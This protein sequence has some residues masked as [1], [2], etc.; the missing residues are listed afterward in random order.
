MNVSSTSTGNAG[1]SGAR[2]TALGIG[3]FGAPS[4]LLHDSLGSENGVFV[5]IVSV[6]AELILNQM[7]IVDVPP[8]IPI[9]D[10]WNVP[11]GV[12]DCASD[13]L[14]KFCVSFH[15][16]LLVSGNEKGDLSQ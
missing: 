2:G 11:G 9:K 12:V 1:K 16:G 8:A 13:K 14:A 3:E 15:V 7:R 4:S 6:D 5:M 10:F